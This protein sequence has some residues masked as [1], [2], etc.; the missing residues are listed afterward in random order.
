[1]ICVVWYNWFW[2]GL[3]FFCIV[4]YVFVLT[5]LAWFRFVSLGWIIADQTF[6]IQHQS[7][8]KVD[9]FFKIVD[10]SYKIVHQTFM[11]VDQILQRSTK[12]WWLST[13]RTTKPQN[14]LQNLEN[15]RPNPGIS[16]LYLENECP[17][18]SF[19]VLINFKTLAVYTKHW[20]PEFRVYFNH[21]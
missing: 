18:Y 16:R 17:I 10:Q 15:S 11:A 1:M 7:F 5:C 8:K 19:S 9:Q 13:K 12:P 21:S 2:L 6:K 4:L 14:I 20:S 3:V